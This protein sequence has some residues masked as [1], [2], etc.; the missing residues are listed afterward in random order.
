MELIDPFRIFPF[1]LL[2]SNNILPLSLALMDSNGNVSFNGQGHRHAWPLDA[3]GPDRIC[4]N[5]LEALMSCFRT[6]IHLNSEDSFNFKIDVQACLEQ[7][8]NH[9]NYFT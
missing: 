7:H 2:G 9:Y 5:L 4:G 8:K 1:S 3:V 6:C